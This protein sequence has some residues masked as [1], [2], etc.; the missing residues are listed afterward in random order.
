MTKRRLKQRGSTQHA[1]LDSELQCRNHSAHISP[2]ILPICLDSFDFIYSPGV[3]TASASTACCILEI[4]RGTEKPAVVQVTAR[5]IFRGLVR[6][7]QEEIENDVSEEQLDILHEVS[8]LIFVKGSVNRVSHLIFSKNEFTLY[9]S[10][11]EKPSSDLFRIFQTK[12]F[13]YEGTV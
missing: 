10:E 4:I 1:V 2:K 8:I 13:D 11:C 5:Q 7:L 6:G 3:I 9:T 12:D